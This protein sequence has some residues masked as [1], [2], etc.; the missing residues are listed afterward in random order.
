MKNNPKILILYENKKFNEPIKYV[1]HLMMS[2]LGIDYR[3]IQIDELNNCKTSEFLLI[4]SYAKERSKVNIKNQIHIYESGF[5][6]ES[7]LK[8]ESL[9]KL[10]IERFNNLPIIYQG[11]KKID[12]HIRKSKDLIETDIDIIA[13]SF[14]MVSRYEEVISKD[15]DRYDRFPVTASLAYKEKFL[16]RPIVNE[17]IELLWGWI[18]S[19]NLGFKRKRLWRD[20]DFVVC[21]THDVDE[22]KRYKFYPPLGA[23]FRVIKQKNF[24][25][26]MIIFFDYLKTKFRL[27]QDIYYETFDYIINLEKKYGFKSS[28]YFMTNGERYSLDNPWLKKTIIRLKKENFEIGIHPS[29]NAYNNLEVLI[30]EKEKLEKI[31]GEKIMGGRQHYLKWKIPESWRIW[32]K[33]GLRYDTT[34][35][36]PDSEGF[37]CGI[38]HPFQPFDILENRIINLWEIPFMVMDTTWVS[39]KL[40]LEE[41]KNILKDF[42]KVIEKYQGVFVLLWHNSY[43]TDLF[44]S[45]WKKIFEEFYNL[46]SQKNCFVSSIK[47]TLNQ[48]SAIL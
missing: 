1:F 13:S 21:L 42:L 47:E 4:V 37:R 34:L 25:K 8:H 27:K 15:K 36:F 19:F 29:F 22:I 35:G 18:D 30:K 16:N 40:L 45:E 6:G 28:F 3:I 11:E 5:F 43:M 23:L 17:Y 44:T 12:G 7:Y 9:P 46:I 2:I 24:K 33:A 48:W 41:K 31:I 14:F 32:E 38:C 39:C 10:P 20:K 26:A